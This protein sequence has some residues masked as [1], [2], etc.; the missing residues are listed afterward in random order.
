MR[1]LQ[2]NVIADSRFQIDPKTAMNYMVD[3]ILRGLNGISGVVAVPTDTRVLSFDGDRK[4]DPK[5]ISYRTTIYVQKTTRLVTW[6]DIYKI[7]NQTQ[8]PTYSFVNIAPIR[9]GG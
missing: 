8:A 3:K 4:G 1:T 6:N 2:F 5:T 7:I 9:K